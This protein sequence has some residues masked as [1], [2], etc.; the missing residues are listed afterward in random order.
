MTARLRIV[1]PAPT[2]GQVR[3]WQSVVREKRIQW[4]IAVTW[5]GG[6]LI[7]IGFWTGLVY[8]ARRW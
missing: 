1:N 4:D 5:I 3:A 6:A 8:L 7:G 2:V